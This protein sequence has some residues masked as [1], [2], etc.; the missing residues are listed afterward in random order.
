[1]A[2]G[3]NSKAVR[4]A[5]AAVV[6]KR[7]TPWGLIATVLVVVVF[8]GAVFGYVYYQGKVKS[9]H[10]AALAP[11]TPSAQN[12]DPSQQIQ[13]V[14]V[15]DYKGGQHVTPDQQVA[16][17]HSPPFGGTHDGYWAACNG[18]V[19][20]NPVRSENLVHSLEHGAVWIAY[21]PDQVTGSALATLRAK[22]EGQPYTVMSPYPNLDS[23]ISLQSWGH[24]L[25]LSD[26]G[27]IR[28]DQFVSALRRNKYT[29]PEVGASCQALGPGEFDQ[30]SPPPFQPAPPV[31]AVNGSSVRSEVEPGANGAAPDPTGTR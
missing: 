21:N 1:M 23:P 25:K 26:A 20:P 14:Q 11:F 12:R 19:Y 31:S 28:I 15:I 16:Y 24:Q 22:V 27:D 18:V 5:R 9:D 4:N 29:H 10:L 6:S 13:G 30:D 2:S 8:A 7:S 17:L 3:K